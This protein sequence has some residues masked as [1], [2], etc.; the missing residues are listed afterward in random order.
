M[1]YSYRCSH[2]GIFEC[3]QKITDDALKTCPD[4]Q[5]EVQRIIVPGA[6]IIFKGSGFYKT[7]TQK[8]IDK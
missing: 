1:I 2:C 6:G 4:C 3:E 8:E 7:D 5:R